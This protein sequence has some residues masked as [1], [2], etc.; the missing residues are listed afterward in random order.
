MGVESAAGAAGEK[1]EPPNELAKGEL[2]A[3]K[4]LVGGAEAVV[5]ETA[6]NGLAAGAAPKPPKPAKGEGF[7]RIVV[8]S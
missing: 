8:A 3:P 2:E 1:L 6:A 4:G 7:C 5:D